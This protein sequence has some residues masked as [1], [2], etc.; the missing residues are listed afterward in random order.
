MHPLCRPLPTNASYQLTQ[1]EF[2]YSFK[3]EVRL[4]TN[5]D[6]DAQPSAG[7]VTNTARTS[8]HEVGLD[9]CAW[10]CAKRAR[11]FSN[12]V[13]HSNVAKLFARCLRLVFTWRKLLNEQFNCVFLV[14]T[15]AINKFLW[16]PLALSVCSPT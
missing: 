2:C 14:C 4:T 12:I 11:L 7:R 10:R 9:A 5:D 15:R 1:F 6:A 13:A 3:N 16:S 8:T